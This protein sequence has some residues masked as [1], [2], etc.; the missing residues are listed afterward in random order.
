MLN[1]QEKGALIG[2]LAA[3]L[4]NL[5]HTTRRLQ[6]GGNFKHDLKR[7]LNLLQAQGEKLLDASQKMFDCQDADAVNV[8]SG[9]LGMAGELLL[10]LT[11]EQIESSLQHM[12]GMAQSNLNYV[13]APILR[14]QAA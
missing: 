2:Q 7:Q 5:D 12:K 13:P 11:P 10:Q 6:E 1:D 8:L 4:V 9:V 3:A 14:S